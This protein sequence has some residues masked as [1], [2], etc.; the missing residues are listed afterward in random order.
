MPRTHGDSRIGTRCYGTQDWALR[1]RTHV[2]GALAVSTLMTVTLFEDTIKTDIF[3]SWREK[4]VLTKLTQTS[5][6]VMDNASC[7]KSKEMQNSLTKAGHILDYLP[8]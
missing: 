6:I 7:H 2:I 3:R 5:V 8:P 1:G 4:D